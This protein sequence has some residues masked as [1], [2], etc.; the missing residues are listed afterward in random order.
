MQE[1][2]QCPLG[3]VC[4]TQEAFDANTSEVIFTRGCFPPMFCDLACASLNESNSGNI[5][6]C[7]T[8]CCNIS[9]CNVGSLPSPTLPTTTTPT[10]STTPTPT[11]TTPLG[12]D[13]DLRL[14]CMILIL[15][16]TVRSNNVT[17]CSI[18]LSL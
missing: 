2:V 18:I 12:K 6:S 14:V 8:E 3:F 1:I 4:F 11:P 10:P 13:K 16:L 17:C 7:V 5:Q 15:D 9:E